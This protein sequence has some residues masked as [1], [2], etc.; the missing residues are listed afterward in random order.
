MAAGVS[1]RWGRVPVWWLQRDDV[2]ADHVAVL[3]AMATHIN[4]DGVCAVS[5]ATLAALLKRSRP[6]VN[7]VI[8]ELS[9]TGILEKTHRTGSNNASLANLYRLNLKP[10]A[11][12]EFAAGA[13]SH[14]G[15]TPCQP[16]DTP[17]HDVD[18]PRH[19]GDT[20]C[21]PADTEQSL[22]NKNTLTLTPARDSQDV[23]KIT[24]EEGW[25]PAEEA[26]LS[27]R[28]VCPDVDIEASIVHF[29]AKSIANG[30]RYEASRT[31]NAWLAWLIEDAE[32][33]QRRG[34]SNRRS[35]AGKA[36][37]DRFSAWGMAANGIPTPRH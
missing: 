21:Q 6:W 9:K 13:P 11:A 33:R 16:A 22:N 2:E 5:Q 24:P 25:R 8:A 29:V 17:R 35:R 12:Q 10:P 32:A 27:A 36:A 26:I 23:I 1:S 37:E 18:I 34:R 28:R 30:Y 7:R 31:S 20:P 19:G 15:D 3:A 14:G 4:E